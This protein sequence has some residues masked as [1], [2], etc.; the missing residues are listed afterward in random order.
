MIWI[1]SSSI[2]SGISLL[3][4]KVIFS[5]SILNKV[6]D[7]L[8]NSM[9]AFEGDVTGKGILLI[10]VGAILVILGIVLKQFVFNKKKEE[11]KEE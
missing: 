3:F 5:A 11:L 1:G 8:G 9:K 2:L 6:K 10:V 7:Y 4:S